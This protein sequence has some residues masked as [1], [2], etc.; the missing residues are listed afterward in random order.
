[1]YEFCVVYFDFGVKNI[2]SSH[3][4]FLTSLV[5]HHDEMVAWRKPFKNVG[6]APT[7]VDEKCDYKVNKHSSEYFMFSLLVTDLC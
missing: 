2:C 4:S 7:G 3:N 5:D 1:M 6:V